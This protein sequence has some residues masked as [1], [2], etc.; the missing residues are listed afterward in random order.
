M[1]GSQQ[2][3]LVRGAVIAGALLALAAPAAADPEGEPPLEMVSTKVQ[4][5]NVYLPGT[6]V[7][8]EGKPRTLSVF[9]T[10]DT[11]HGFSIAGTNVEE[12]LPPGK[13][14]VV[15]VPPLEAGIYRIDCQLHPPHRSAQLLVIEVDD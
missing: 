10:T 7:I 14:H 3:R 5:K 8:E 4:G 12:V 15:K 1:T 6:I 11:P 2:G 13:E 9:N